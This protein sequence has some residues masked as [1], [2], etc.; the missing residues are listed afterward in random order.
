MG[1]LEVAEWGLMMM[2]DAIIAA[3]CDVHRW[4]YRFLGQDRMWAGIVYEGSLLDL[5]EA[6]PLFATARAH[7]FCLQN[8]SRD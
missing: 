5:P 4:T 1:L 2:D 7:F 3:R 6:T 8:L